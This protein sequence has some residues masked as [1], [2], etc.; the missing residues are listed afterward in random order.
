MSRRIVVLHLGDSVL[1]P[2]GCIAKFLKIPVCVTVHGRDV[3]YANPLYKLWL[4]TFFRDFDAYICVSATTRDAAVAAGAPIARTS[5]IGNGVTPFAA[6]NSIR[7]NDLLLFVGR[8]VRRKGLAWFVRVVLPTI[9][10]CHDRV[11]L[12]IIGAGP[13]RSAIQAAADEAG[14]SDRS[15]GSEHYQTTERR[16][17]LSGRDVA[18]PETWRDRANRGLRIRALEAAAAGCALI[19][20]DLEGLRDSIVD[21][22]GGRLIRSE[23]AAAWTA[24]IVELLEDPDATRQQWAHAHA[25]GHGGARLGICL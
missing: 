22:Q 23:D 16:W 20:A 15:S 4:R 21:G 17:W 2:L 9:A 11:R 14:V 10:R 5:I 12:A 7:D 24:A 13:E 8:L 1:S 3:T 25:F 6:S 19:A 18:S